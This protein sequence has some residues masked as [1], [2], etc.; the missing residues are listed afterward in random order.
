MNVIEKIKKWQLVNTLKRQIVRY[1]KNDNNSEPLYLF[2]YYGDEENSSELNSLQDFADGL[3]HKLGLLTQ[4]SDIK[5]WH[6]CTSDGKKLPETYFG[7]PYQ[8]GFIAAK[9]GDRIFRFYDNKDYQFETPKLFEIYGAT[10]ASKT[11]RLNGNKENRREVLNIECTLEY[12][13]LIPQRIIRRYVDAPSLPV[14][15]WVKEKNKYNRLS[16]V[17]S[18]AK[19]IAWQL[20]HDYSYY[21]FPY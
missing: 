20:E 8:K 21:E 1:L 15:I 9:A 12:A 18:E 17:R 6:I 14:A 2:C 3:F 16:A 7:F 11:P 13:E 19:K 5:V 10:L 4:K